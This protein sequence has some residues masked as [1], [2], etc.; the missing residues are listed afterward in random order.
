MSLAERLEQARRGHVATHD[1]C[2]SRAAVRLRLRR[3]VDPFAA[4]KASVHQALLGQPRPAAVRPA[5][6]SRPSSSSRSGTRSRRSSTPRRPRSRAADRTRIAQEVADEILGHGPLEPLLRDPEITE[7]MV[8][9]PD[10]IYVER[11]GKI[12]PGRRRVQPTTPTCA[13]PSTRSSAG[14]A[15]ASTRPA[16]WSTPACPT[17]PGSTRSSRRSPSTAPC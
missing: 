5:P 11:A 8:N 10:Q 1:A 9:G 17:A 3:G 13:A 2:R 4:V 14:S 16:R 15:G 12:Y 6:A 7:I